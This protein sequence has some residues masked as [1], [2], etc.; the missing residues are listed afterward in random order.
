MGNCE[1]CMDEHR[2]CNMVSEGM[3]MLGWGVMKVCLVG[4]PGGGLAGMCCHVQSSVWPIEV[5][6]S[7]LTRVWPMNTSPSGLLLRKEF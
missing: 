6:V 7:P 1:G 2:S 3:G 4:P 5:L